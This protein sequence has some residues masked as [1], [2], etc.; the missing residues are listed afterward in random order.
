MKE[1]NLQDLKLDRDK[2]KIIFKAIDKSIYL[3]AIYVAGHPSDEYQAVFSL[4][5]I[6][7][8]NRI[9]KLLLKSES[10][11]D[12]TIDSDD[13]DVLCMA[14]KR[15]YHK[16]KEEM[17]IEFLKELSDQLA[18]FTKDEDE[19]AAPDEDTTIYEFLEL[20]EDAYVQWVE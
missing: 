4:Y 20:G 18:E 15:Y 13:C 5:E 1:L 6:R 16:N 9:Q 7:E 19:T 8:L 3:N 10:V 11:D 17:D 12:V 2:L 14:I